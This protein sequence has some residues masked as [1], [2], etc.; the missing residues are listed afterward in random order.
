M[1]DCRLVIE[2][3][4]GEIQ[5]RPERAGMEELAGMCGVLMQVVGLAAFRGGMPLD[6]IKNHMYDIYFNAMEAMVDQII[7]ERG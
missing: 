7:E 4:N 1:K 5:F 6:D 2:A 3:Q